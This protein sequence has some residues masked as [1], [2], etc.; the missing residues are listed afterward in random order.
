MELWKYSILVFLGGCSY[1][2]VS[3][4]VKLAYEDGFTVSDV[5][6]SQYFCAAIITWLVAIFVPKIKL[7]VKQCLILLIS[8]MPMGLTGVFYNK[9][10]GYINASFAVILLLQYIWIN[11]GLQYILVKKVPSIRNIISIVVILFGSF[12]ASDVFKSDISFS[13]I[14]IGWGLLAALSFATFVYVS[15]RASIPIHPIY[16]S[17][18]MTSGAGLVVMILMPPMFLFNGVLINGLLKYGILTGLF[19]SIFP[20]VL[21]SIGMPKVCS[22][23]NILCASELPM[24]VSM[25]TLVLGETVNFSRWLG[26]IFILIGIAYPNLEKN[27]LPSL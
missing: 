10:L 13:W 9:S 20:L 22:L 5:T 15:G 16:K 24:A 3:T 4:F 25:S 19:G 11:Q 17:A 14:G 1:G 12:F 2:V 23:G 7:S 6:G 8:G 21:F 26:V 27:R 18:I